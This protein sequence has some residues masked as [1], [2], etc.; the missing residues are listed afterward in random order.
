MK[1]ILNMTNVIL[2]LYK[3]IYVSNKLIILQYMSIPYFPQRLIRLL[4]DYELFAG[5]TAPYQEVGA[6]LR[7]RAD[8]QV[9]ISGA[10]GT[11]HRGLQDLSLEQEIPCVLVTIS[12]SVNFVVLGHIE[13]DSKISN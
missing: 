11:G 4:Y 13:N 3:I 8:H 2:L 10:A 5:R 6:G 12:D 1:T 7:C 9:L